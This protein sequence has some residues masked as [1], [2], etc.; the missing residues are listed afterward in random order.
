[1]HLQQLKLGL[2]FFSLHL[3]LFFPGQHLFTSVPLCLTAARARRHQPLSDRAD[4]SVWRYQDDAVRAQHGVAFGW[5]MFLSCW[6]CASNTSSFISVCLCLV[7]CASGWLLFGA[8]AS[9]ALC[10]PA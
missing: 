8:V 2:C 3:F 9:V 7:Q 4:G 6:V 1:M 10:L 5:T